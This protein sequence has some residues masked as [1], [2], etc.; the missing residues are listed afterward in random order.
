MG[1]M[2]LAEIMDRA[3][4]ILKKYIKT[5]I[6]FTLAFGV[7]MFIFVFLL[8][9]IMAVFAGVSFGIVKSAVPF[10]VSVVIALIIGITISLVQN[11]GMI[12]ISSQE[13]L[14][15]EVLTDT[16]LKASF[17]N[18]FKAGGI[19][20]CSIGLFI[21]VIAVI[22]WAGY[23]LFKHLEEVLPLMS[24]GFI[25]NTNII[26][27][28]ISAVLFVLISIFVI[29]CCITLIMFSFHALTLE[30]KGVFASMKRSFNLVKHSFWKLLGCTIL[31]SLTLYGIRFS[32]DSFFALIGGLIYLFMKFLN[33]PQDLLSMV[34][35]AATYLQFPL[36]IVYWLL[37]SPI[38]YIMIT[39]LY[40]NERFKKEGF[41]LTLRLKEIGKD[42]ETSSI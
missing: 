24:T 6:L 31:I 3:I 34:T 39:L 42:D 33:I 22:G 17:K 23:N 14:E 26:L 7:V 32:I 5:I 11:I 19:V 29:L 30:N 37:V 25:S 2:T 38:G 4:E 20:L 15:G 40:F 8:I 21:P 27:L 10:I 18:I 1:I 16:A 35:M 9:I 12:K 36:S 13:F 28:I 41:D